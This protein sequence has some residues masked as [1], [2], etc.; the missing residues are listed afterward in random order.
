[1][2]AG[3]AIHGAGDAAISM[4]NIKAVLQYDG[5]EYHGW[6]IQP[7][8]RTIQ[9]VLTEAL[10]QLDQRPVIVHGAGR[11]DAGAHAEGQVANFFLSRRW[12]TADLIR[13]INACLPRDI[14]VV[15]ASPVDPLFH[16]RFDA[17]AKTYRYRFYLGRVVS[18]FLYRYVYPCF[19]PLNVSRMQEAC[20]LLL[21]KHDFAAFSSRSQ[22]RSTTIRVITEITLVE[23]DH[24]LELCVTAD[25]FL[26]AMVRRLAGTLQEV[27]R[28]RMSL[29]Q[30]A[31]LLHHD[32][33]VEAGPTLPAQGLTLLR[34]DY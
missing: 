6:Q 28:G 13:A 30:V 27:G 29:E 34:V 3:D 32:P 11:T 17:K 19:Y 16:A 26:R 21:G 4:N 14:R 8:R 23:S 22:E 1:M 9:G 31:A 7:G 15:E 20:S 12:A 18:P 24:M 33:A 5:T 25:G 10:S 2:S